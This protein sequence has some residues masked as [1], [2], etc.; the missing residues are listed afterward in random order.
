MKFFKQFF[1]DIDFTNTNSRGEVQVLCPFPHRYTSDGKPIYE[2][3]ASAGINTE[4]GLFHCFTCGIGLTEV[5]FASKVQGVSFKE[6]T[7]LLTRL[8]ECNGDWSQFESAL[9]DSP[10][11]LQSLLDFGFTEQVLK[12]CRIG[13]TGEGMMAVP[14]FL[15]G[16]LMD[17]KTYKPN[18]KPKWKSLEGA[19][20]GFITPF[21][22]W[23]ND[24]RPTLICAGE[25]DMLIAR[26]NNYNAITVTGGEMA[27]PKY[28]KSFFNDKDCFIIYDNDDTGKKGALSLATFIKENGGRPRVVT[29]H[30]AV[31]VDKGEDLYDYFQKY[32]KNREDLNEILYNTEE[33]TEED[34]QKEKRKEM[35]LISLGEAVKSKY[36]GKLLNSIVQVTSVYDTQYSVADLIEFTK[37]PEV[38]INEKSAFSGY[39]EI[40][41]VVI[42]DN[43]ISRILY[44][45]EKENIANSYYRKFAGIPNNEIGVI[46]K[47]LSHLTIYRASVIDFKEGDSD[48]VVG[49]DAELVPTETQAFLV[50]YNVQNGGKYLMTYRM[51][52]H[53]LDDQQL[54]MV[55]T[56]I[57]D[58]NDSISSFRVTEE[59]KSYLKLFQ[60]DPA[61]KMKEMLLRSKSI[62]GKFVVDKI[63][64][65]VDLF[66]HTPLQF[67]YGNRLLRGY[68]DTMIIGDTRTGKSQTASCLLNKYKLGTFLSLKTSTTVGLIGGSK[69]VNGGG[70]KNT[71][72]A[73]PRNNKGA[74]IMEEFQ[75]APENFIS[76][77]TDIRTSNKVHI[78]R[79]DGEL[80]V[81]AMVRMLTISNQA[82]TK[83]GSKPLRSYPNGVEVIQE[84]IQASEDISRY[85][86]F[87]VVEEPQKYTSPFAEVDI[88]P[89]LADEAYQTRVRWAW[90]RT[91]E[92][93]IFDTGVQE[94]IWEK[95]EKLNEDF[96]CHIKFFGSE[97]DIKLARI[98]V[99]V[100]SCLCSTDESFE[101]V[102][103][104]QEHVDWA[105]AWLYHLYD[106]DLF[107]LKEYAKEER[108]YSEI[109]D[110][111]IEV[112][113]G[114]YRMNTVLFTQLEHSSNCT[115]QNLQ[116]VSGL[117]NQGFSIVL[118]DLTRYKLIKWQRD[119]IVPT[120]RF[121]KTMRNI[122]RYSSM[123]KK[124]E[125]R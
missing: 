52:P 62:V 26:S 94:Y 36:R 33:F 75:G 87:A 122:E 91:P 113:E 25:K 115:R 8:E 99:A 80:T 28:F 40:K 123:K 69:N 81:D 44:L 100:A 13:H 38:E 50:D 9:W 68:L 72:G 108:S 89:A 41:R 37:S 57:K 18:E 95:S 55:V 35:P 74:V 63:F 102:I 103:I 54:V 104:K 30:H 112:V 110:E 16:V 85:D 97:A 117:D 7:L 65:T 23:V 70:W 14:V 125:V 90:S 76:S 119:K 21:D 59:V 1:K 78:V 61:E 92:Q 77:L 11:C 105:V 82:S 19:L 106:N 51:I 34:Y 58:A 121:R 17:I 107:R 118:N 88:L 4:T 2:E 66:Y 31:C 86:F 3:H 20:A 93:I 84:L 120:E 12:E 64:Y 27:L 98:S 71:I 46:Q 67:Y 56:D 96:N 83:E 47:K 24:P 101:K 60:G 15:Y 49:T 6:A 29:G 48:T 10:Y 109:D 53:P 42:D 114:L 43:N 45:M 111:I 22:L 79:A 32:G 73:I 124:G 116:A 5:Q 39:D